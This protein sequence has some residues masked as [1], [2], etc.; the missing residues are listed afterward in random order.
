ML[1]WGVVRFFFP[2][3]L[4]MLWKSMQRR[5]VS[6]FFLMKKNPALRG[7]DDGRIIP[8]AR[9]CGTFLHGFLLGFRQTI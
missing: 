5:S 3:I 1:R 9:L 4:F 2:V 6:S 8:A 7:D